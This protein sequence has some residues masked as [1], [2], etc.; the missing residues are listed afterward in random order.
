MKELEE[1][2]IRELK[3]AIYEK[4]EEAAKIFSSTLPTNYYP[5]EE[6]EIIDNTDVRNISKSYFHLH[7][8]DG[9]EGHDYLAEVISGTFDGA[10][11]DKI[12]N[13]IIHNYITK[14]KKGGWDSY[15]ED[16]SIEE[17]GRYGIT[18]IT[19]DNNDEEDGEEQD[20]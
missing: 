11:E 9:C 13:S 17:V 5:Y 2:S 19:M 20:G 6:T 16:V 7:I 15:F 18:F 8:N 10:M 14:A 12:K 3:D 1:Y 4:Q